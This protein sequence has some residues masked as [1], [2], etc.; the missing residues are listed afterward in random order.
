MI[1]RSSARAPK[2]LAVVKYQGS[3]TRQ[4]HI[5]L[6]RSTDG[7]FHELTNMRIKTPWIE[8]LRR[9]RE[10]GIDLIGRSSTSSVLVDRDLTP[11][12]M[13]DSF[14]RVVRSW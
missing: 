3:I 1:C 13:S 14:H 7:V 9:Q 8:A 2:S 10:G 5:T 4:L 12:K 11:K 6:P